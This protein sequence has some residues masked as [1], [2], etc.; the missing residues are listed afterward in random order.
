MN[1]KQGVCMGIDAPRL[2]NNYVTARNTYLSRILR[3]VPGIPHLL[4]RSV[5]ERL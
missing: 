4:P 1:Q 3:E 2:S 5:V